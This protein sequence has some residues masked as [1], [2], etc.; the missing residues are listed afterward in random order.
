MLYTRDELMEVDNDNY[1]SGIEG[2]DI[3]KSKEE[4]PVMASLSESYF[5]LDVILVNTNK[6][7]FCSTLHYLLTI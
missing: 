1:N 2:E 6:H 7:S 3:Y 4:K 5:K